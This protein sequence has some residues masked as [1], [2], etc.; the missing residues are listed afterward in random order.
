MYHQLTG[1]E[2]MVVGTVAKAE[3]AVEHLDM[4]TN[5]AVD[6]AVATTGLRLLLP[7]RV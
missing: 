4:A 3:E 5:P 1:E 6:M 2:A 7:L